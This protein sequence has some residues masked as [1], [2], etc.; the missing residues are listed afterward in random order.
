MDLAFKS[1]IVG[2]RASSSFR[3][4]SIKVETNLTPQR[5]SFKRVLLLLADARAVRL[6]DTTDNTFAG[7]KIQNLNLGKMNV[8]IY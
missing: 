6:P 7:T 8:C 1:L 4:L 5:L 2:T 3:M